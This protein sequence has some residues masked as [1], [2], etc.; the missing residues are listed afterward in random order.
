MR[1]CATVSSNL[2]CYTSSH[3][4]CG[5]IDCG[6][7]LLTN[8]PRTSVAS[9]KLHPVKVFT[10]SVEPRLTCQELKK[11]IAHSLEEISR[12]LLSVPSVVD[13]G[14][15]ELLIGSAPRQ[16]DVGAQLPPG[17]SQ[18]MCWCFPHNVE[19]IPPTALLNK[20]TLHYYNR[21]IFTKSSEDYG[22]HFF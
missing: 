9:W 5:S 22:S 16:V 19:M 15:A 1:A 18:T 13:S 12:F 20:H 21:R 3:P 10:V 8:C 14:Q 17:H 6:P 7:G 2:S 4:Q 11:S